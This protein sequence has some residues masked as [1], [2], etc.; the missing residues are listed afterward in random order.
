MKAN[1]SFTS[2]YGALDGASFVIEAATEDLELK[3]RIFADLE[4][5]RRARRVVRLEL[6]TPRAGAHLRGAVGPVQVDGDSLLLSCRAQ[7]RRRGRARGGY[8]RFESRLGDALL[9][10]DRQVAASH[11]QPLRLRD[12]PHLRGPLPGRRSLRRGGPRDHPRGGLRRSR[13]SRP[14]RGPL[15]R[16]EPHR[17]QPHHGARSRRAATSA[18]THGSARPS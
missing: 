10:G 17:R 8:R 5:A 18:S 15:H 3:R 4:P 14:G 16:D 12:R 13:G 2:D 1:I 9:R 6:V 7:P 11:R